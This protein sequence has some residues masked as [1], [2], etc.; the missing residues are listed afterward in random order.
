MAIKYWPAFSIVDRFV[1]LG[2]ATPLH[3][4]WTEDR[5]AEGLIEEQRAIRVHAG[6]LQVLAV[7]SFRQ[8]EPVRGTCTIEVRTALDTRTL[9]EKL[10]VAIVA[11]AG[12]ALGIHI[13]DH[14]LILP[15]EAPSFYQSVRSD[16]TQPKLL[17]GFKEI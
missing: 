3:R 16:G 12:S 15:V 7:V 6:M 9:Y 2:K 17:H 14:V 8:V 5:I 1:Q 13:A 4:H 10:G 11:S